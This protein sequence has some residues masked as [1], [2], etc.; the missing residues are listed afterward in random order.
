MY[1]K[2]V[3]HSFIDY[4]SATKR[5]EVLIQTI[6]WM[7]ITDIMLSKRSQTFKKGHTLLFYYTK[8]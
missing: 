2:N 7:I 8:L 5:N 4:Y 6:T 3:I 1:E